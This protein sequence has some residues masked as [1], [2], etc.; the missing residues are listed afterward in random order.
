MI[1][2]AY[3][4]SQNIRDI[5]EI[6]MDPNFADKFSSIIVQEFMGDVI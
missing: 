2:E 1:L 3:I 5:K 6:Q 4:L